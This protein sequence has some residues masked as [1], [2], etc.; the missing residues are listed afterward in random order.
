VRNFAQRAGV[1]PST[2]QAVLQ[3][4]RPIVDTLVAI[5]RAGGVSVD[6]LATGEGPKSLGEVHSVHAFAE[7]TGSDPDGGYELQLMRQCI[8][9]IEE[10]L[11]EF[12]KQLEP[13]AKASVIIDLYGLQKDEKLRTG[14]SLA[15]AKVIQLV[16][17]A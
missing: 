3:G 8:I 11:A 1:K 12:G 2:L 6:W 16:R 17:A 4:T 13:Q 10:I 7:S 15:V 5:A 14:N 9:D